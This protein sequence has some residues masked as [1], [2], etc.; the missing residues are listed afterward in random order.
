MAIKLDMEKAYERVEWDFTLKGLQDLGFDMKWIEWVEQC[1][2]TT[3]FS[4]LMNENPVGMIK[5][6]RDLRQGDPLS[7]YLF[8]IYMEILSR[9]LM[10]EAAKK[11][12]G[13]GFKIDRNGPIIPCLLFAD[14][15][16]IFYK[17]D[18]SIA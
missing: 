17:A 13:V 4:I 18:K 10:S 12:S 5:P 8:L 1:I 2:K 14:D 6:S 16:L 7:P 11:K 15:S 9:M 3:S